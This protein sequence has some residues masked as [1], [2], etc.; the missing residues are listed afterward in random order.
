MQDEI[1]KV[2]V[3][4]ETLSN[5]LEF[6][7]L[8]VMQ[9]GDVDPLSPVLHRGDIAKAT[10]SNLSRVLTETRLSKDLRLRLWRSSVVLSLMQGCEAWEITQDVKQ[11]L[12]GIVPKMLAKITGR[13]IAEEANEETSPVLLWIKDRR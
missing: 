5:V 12:N 13:S 3:G 4:D 10:F 8:G 11:K 1:A 7:Y 6:N 2:S 9:S